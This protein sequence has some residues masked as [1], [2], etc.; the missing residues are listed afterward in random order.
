VG[1][2]AGMDV[3]EERKIFPLPGFDHAMSFFEVCHP[4]C[5][6]KL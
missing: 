3:S 1:P 6:F 5:V 4:R 2:N